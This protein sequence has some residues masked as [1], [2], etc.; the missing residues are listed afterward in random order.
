[1]IYID[2]IKFPSAAEVDNYRY[3]SLYP[4]NI[5]FE[6]SFEWMIC[7][8]ITI[9]YGNNGSGKSTILNLIASKINATRHTEIYSDILYEDNGSEIQPFEDMKDDITIKNG[10]DDFGKKLKLPLNIKL[11]TSDDIFKK[12]NDRL[13]HNNISIEKNRE[14]LNNQ[15]MYK[16]EAFDGW[17]LKSLEEVD[18][19]KAIIE[20][21]RLS[22]R[23]Y[24]RVHSTSKE[25]LKSNGE[26]A[27]EI[28]SQTFESGGLYLLDEPEN[29][30]S[31]IFQLELMNLISDA[32]KY[33]KCQFIIATHSPLILSLN[34]SII[35]NLDSRPV[36][37]DRWS[38]LDN[39]K[40]YYKFFKSHKD[41]FE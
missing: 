3:P 19:L 12:I 16:K 22:F 38:N 28:F 10:Y 8:D 17:Q 13:T 1:M 27:I 18:H 15:R 33:Y 26:T 39:V 21:Q 23:E 32:V 36:I 30:L 4:W 35:Y 34:N 40:I 29:C 6:N 20:A 5:F 7:K 41:E 25:R 24:M 2:T 11:L 31:P 14:T 37:S 9:L